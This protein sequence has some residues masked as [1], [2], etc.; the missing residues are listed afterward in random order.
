MA[1]VGATIGITLVR[2]T[3]IFATWF[4]C[5]AHL[6]VRVDIAKLR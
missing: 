1:A 3:S 2:T 5:M 4:P 6:A